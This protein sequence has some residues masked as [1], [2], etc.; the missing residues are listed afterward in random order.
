MSVSD[1]K[2]SYLIRFSILIIISIILNIS[3]YYI[4]SIFP[5][6]FRVHTIGT[7]VA[8]LAGGFIPGTISIFITNLI[9]K[10]IINE[11]VYY[12]AFNFIIVILVSIIRRHFIEREISP[13]VIHYGRG[14]YP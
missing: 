6:Q 12:T 7:I 13:T 5:V 9:F 10:A 1:K 11:G 3:G 14:F 8:T 4:A 2:K